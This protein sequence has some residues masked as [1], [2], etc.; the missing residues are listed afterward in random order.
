MKGAE[1][2]SRALSAVKDGGGVGGGGR[3]R[4]RRC[5]LV[6]WKVSC[7]QLVVATRL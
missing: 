1:G 6:T 7:S 4:L 3:G 5:L 2:M